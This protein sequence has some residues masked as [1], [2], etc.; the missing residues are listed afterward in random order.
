MIACEKLLKNMF[1]IFSK[2]FIYFSRLEYFSI[3]E[4]CLKE[5]GGAGEEVGGEEEGEKLSTHAGNY[6]I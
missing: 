1:F 4:C 3:N 5:G 2:L 6:I